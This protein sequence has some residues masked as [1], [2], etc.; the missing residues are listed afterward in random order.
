MREEPIFDVPRTTAR[1][2]ET[3][4]FDGGGITVTNTRFVVPG[5]TYAMASVTSV[6][7]LEKPQSWIMGAVCGALAIW[8]LT[9]GTFM[10]P[11]VVVFAGISSLALWRGRPRYDVILSTAAGEVRAL[12]S[13]ERGDVRQVVKALNDAI[14]FRG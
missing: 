13:H 8:W 3:V 10:I 5:Q 12:S 4:F 14:I 6:R 2:P 1:A 11:L 7:Y 9:I